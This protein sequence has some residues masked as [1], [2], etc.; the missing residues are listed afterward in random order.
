VPGAPLSSDLVDAFGRRVV[1]AASAAPGRVELRSTEPR[2]GP[3]GLERLDGSPW[4][5]GDVVGDFAL[6]ATVPSDGPCQIFLAHKQSPVGFL[7]RVLVKH[8]PRSSPRFFDG[9][10]ALYAEARA[11]AF[12]EHPGI[13]EL[14]DFQESDAGVHLARG[15]VDGTDLGT[16]TS[17]LRARGEALPFELACHIL[18]ELTRGLEAA[19]AAQGPDGRA[20]AITHLALS[21]EHVLVG[22]TGHV[23]LVGFGSRIRVLE[24]TDIARAPQEV[25]EVSYVAPEIPATRAGDWRSDIHA[26]GVL[27]FELLTGRPCFRGKSVGEILDKVARRDLRLERLGE[28]GVPP[29]LAKV[30]ERAVATDP[31][32]RFPTAG[33]MANAID[34]WMAQSGL[35]VGAWILAAFCQQHD[36]MPP[37]ELWVAHPVEPPRDPTADTR[38]TAPAIPPAQTPSDFGAARPATVQ[39]AQTPALAMGIAA[40][41]PP[42]ATSGPEAPLPV[43]LGS[44][45][46]PAP[47]SGY[48]PGA[49][50]Y[51]ALAYGAPPYAVAGGAP[52]GYP[53]SSNSPAFSATHQHPGY[54]HGA[55]GFTAPGGGYPASA[56]GY[57]VPP[58]APNPSVPFGYPTPGAPTSPSG[59]LTPANPTARGLPPHAAMAPGAPRQ[60][61][62]AAAYGPMQPAPMPS[63]PMPSAPLPTGGGAFGG[64]P[65]PSHAASPQGP[66]ASNPA[67]LQTRPENPNSFG[68]PRLRP[69]EPGPQAVAAGPPPPST[70]PISWG[71][72]LRAPEASGVPEVARPPEPARVPE[73][74]IERDA[75]PG[76]AT[77]PTLPSQGGLLGVA[78][79]PETPPPITA[80]VRGPVPPP[81]ERTAPSARVPSSDA[82]LRVPPPRPPT[83]PEGPADRTR[84]HI[85]PDI[86]EEAAQA[87]SGELASTRPLDVV[88]RLAAAGATGVLELRA[89]SVWKRLTFI[90]GEGAE[91]SS[92]IGLEGLGEQLVRAKLLQR[93]ELDKAL[94]ESPRGEG[95]LAERLLATNTLTR[96]QLATELEKLVR[97]ALVDVFAWRQGVFAFVPQSLTVPVVH[98]H[99]DLAELVRREQNRA[100]PSFPPPDATRTSNDPS[101]RGRR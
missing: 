56:A 10:R 66:P 9:R 27:F 14:V 58:T 95:G 86:A 70:A 83:E 40:S 75:A 59:V 39:A 57:P 16:I 4:R 6:V 5:P 26:A 12:L 77:S 60:G 71:P 63:A 74:G 55:I 35:H 88:A 2:T 29:D 89:G 24:A 50:P 67:L 91:I 13:A 76:A 42:T 11:L 15:F 43:D 53:P 46:Y 78:R 41:G 85:M 64:G 18:T 100:R 101:R 92:N 52:Q 44:P 80:P 47:P 33:D 73:F 99:V 96:E 81:E 22:R 1:E 25:P 3:R 54:P 20:A 38:T 30:V 82:G 93:P 7:R 34:S 65:P 48:G 69:S 23:K 94:R 51:G 98:P 19:H 49:L 21:P 87:W 79:S 36:L 37:T 62:P 90:R 97:E 32:E 28:E 84:A 8:V 31:E 72:D 45:S 68:P 17:R 61:G